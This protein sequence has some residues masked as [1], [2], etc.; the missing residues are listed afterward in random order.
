MATRDLTHDGTAVTKR[1]GVYTALK[2]SDEVDTQ[3]AT[4]FADQRIALRA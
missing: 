1:S 3:K 2:A 4:A